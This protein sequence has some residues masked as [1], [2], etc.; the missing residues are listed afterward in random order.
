MRD[1]T[2]IKTVSFT[3]R[4]LFFIENFIYM[5]TLCL[6]D[7]VIFWY[8]QGK[9]LLVGE[10]KSRALGIERMVNAMKRLFFW[11]K[12]CLIKDNR[13]CKS[14]CVNCPYYEDCSRDDI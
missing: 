8:K 3:W 13:G 6:C 14:F 4:G 7:L 5:D 10:R 12:N 2:I 9:V 1:F 11:I